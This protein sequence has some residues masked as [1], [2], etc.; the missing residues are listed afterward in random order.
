MLD[1][2]TNYFG[3]KSP[4]EILIVVLV[5]AVMF[6]IVKKWI[7][8]SIGDLIKK[9]TPPTPHDGTDGSDISDA[10]KE[11]LRGLVDSLYDSIYC[12]FCTRGYFFDEVNK[13]LGLNDSE[14]ILFNKYYGE[15]SDNT[16]YFDVDWEFAPESSADD[17]LLGRLEE[18]NI[19]QKG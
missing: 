6:W 11:Y 7:F 1:K 18:L 14:L 15:K 5:I 13:V 19:S 3:S 4:K 16:L 17:D 12:V 8:P 10:R 9:I 2:I